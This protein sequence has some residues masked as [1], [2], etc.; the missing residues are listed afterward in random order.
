MSFILITFHRELN[1]SKLNKCECKIKREDLLKEKKMLHSCFSKFKENISVI[2]DFFFLFIRQIK[3]CNNC[4]QKYYNFK[5]CYLF[6]FSLSDIYIHFNNGNQNYTNNI[7]IKDCFNYFQRINT[8]IKQNYF[9]CISCYNNSYFNV[10]N[11]LYATT[12]FILISLNYDNTQNQN[13]K[14]EIS[15]NLELNILNGIIKYELCSIVGTSNEKD[16]NDR[17]ITYFKNDIDNKWNYYF[18]NENN[19]INNFEDEIKNKCK[20]YFLMFHQK[21]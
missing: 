15:E 9:K 6:D 3:E 18:N 12:Q 2:S 10:S 13:I 17:I 21:K 19:L 20:P 16:K 7:S 11:I 14:F 8:I 1:R 5:I 4:H